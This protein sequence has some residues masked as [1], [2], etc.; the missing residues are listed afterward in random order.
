M[1]LEEQL[2]KA[3]WAL[4]YIS[5]NALSV[6][7]KGFALNTL[8]EMGMTADEYLEAQPWINKQEMK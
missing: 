3:K 5:A 1:T 7:I 8:K 6:D 2:E 4:V